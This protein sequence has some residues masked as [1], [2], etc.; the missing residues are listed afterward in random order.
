MPAHRDPGGDSGLVPRNADGIGSRPASGL[1][2]Q[3]PSPQPPALPGGTQKLVRKLQARHVRY[4][5]SG[6][7]KSAHGGRSWRRK[8]ES[9][10]TTVWTL[11]RSSPRT[12]RCYVAADRRQGNPAQ[13]P[14]PDLLPDQRRRPRGD[15]RGGRHGAQAGHDW[16]YPYYRDRA[17]CLALGMTPSRCSCSGRRRRRPIRTRGGRQMPSHWGHKA[18]QHRLAVEPDRHAVPAGG[19]VRRGRHATTAQHPEPP[20]QQASIRR[21]RLRLGRR[22]HDER[23][24]VLGGAQHARA[25]CKLPVAVSRRGQ[26][27]RDFGAGRGADRRAAASRGSCVNF[28]SLCRDRGATAA[29]SLAAYA[30]CRT[31]SRTAGRGSGPAL[32]HAHV[33][34]PY[35]HSLSDDERLYRPPAERERRDRRAI[36]C[37]SFAKFLAAEGWRPRRRSRVDRGRRSTRQIDEAAERALQ[38]PQPAAGQRAR[39]GVYSPDVDPTSAAFDTPKTAGRASPRR[40][41]IS[42]TRA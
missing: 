26:R 39:A 37:V 15:P 5:R 2:P 36:P 8:H 42:S 20:R 14:E 24:R 33:I 11:R 3:A 13:A 41:W 25:T 7:L 9:R 40:W 32:V 22:R 21:S 1:R 27:L 30:R 4:P 29:T 31:P 12:G 18:A 38:A 35:S 28:P 6:A 34:R 19:R 23:G 16:F 17:L 10:N